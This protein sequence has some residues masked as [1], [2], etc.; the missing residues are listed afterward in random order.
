MTTSLDPIFSTGFGNL[1]A[2]CTAA[3]TTMADVTNAVRLSSEGANWAAGVEGAIINRM[4]ARCIASGA[5]ADTLCY[6]F[7][8]ADDG[9]TLCLKAAAKF[10]AQTVNT[11]TVSAVV[12]LD[13]TFD[14]PLQLSPG[15]WLYAAISVAQATGFQFEGSYED[16]AA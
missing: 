13:A 10:T 4:K 1:V 12:D 3:K 2:K 14:E 8:S 11:T 15:E 6:L 9:T 5:I 7:T 16:F